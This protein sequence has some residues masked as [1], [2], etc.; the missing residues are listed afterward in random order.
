MSEKQNNFSIKLAKMVIPEFK[1]SKDYDKNYYTPGIDGKWFDNLI[2]LYDNCSTHSAIINNLKRRICKDNEN[3]EVLDKITLDFL[4]TGSYAMQV[5]WNINHTEIIKLV[6]LD[7]S[8]V[9]TGLINPDTDE[10]SLYYYSNDWLK[11]NNRKIV[12]F[13]P[14][15]IDKNADDDQI[16]YYKRYNPNGTD[17]H[18]YPKPY[19]FSCL[20][21]IYTK[22]QI[23]TYYANLT[24]NNFVANCIL[25]LNS[26]MDDEKAEAFEKSLKNNFAGSENAGSMMVLYSDN[27]ENKPEL[28]KFNSEGDDEKYARLNEDVINEIM[29]GHNIPPALGGI[30]ISGKLGNSAEL[31]VYE[32]IY[33]DFVVSP[34]RNEIFKEYNELKNYIKP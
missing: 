1:Q 14:Y 27:S 18:V 17:W 8:K 23:D 32:Q 34:F 30:Q 31:A 24:A 29:V 5:Q 9:R 7:V 6:H 28:I 20:K 4:I 16:F 22:I 11:Y 2:Y 25:S 3:D 21:S 12:P 15:S 10:P 13:Y 19:Y 33:D 26:F